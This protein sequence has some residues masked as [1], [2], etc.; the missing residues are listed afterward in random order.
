M[1]NLNA[2][3]GNSVFTVN[4]S[5]FKSKICDVSNSPL[6][7]AN[8]LEFSWVSLH[9]VDLNNCSVEVQSCCKCE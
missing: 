1:I 8:C 2:E 7:K 6:A 5:V 3:K 9:M 4:G